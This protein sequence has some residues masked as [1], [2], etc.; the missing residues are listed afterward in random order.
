MSSITATSIFIGSNDAPAR[1]YSA[2]TT[3]LAI[4]QFYDDLLSTG[5]FNVATL[6]D[7]RHGQRLLAIVNISVFLHVA[8][9]IADYATSCATPEH[10]EVLSDND[11]SIYIIISPKAAQ[12]DFFEFISNFVSSYSDTCSDITNKTVARLKEVFTSYT[13]E[14]NIKFLINYKLSL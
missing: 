4:E 6:T 13:N 8:Q 1:T 12:E 9:A 2:A 11:E 14:P 5:H 3:D 7:P 10:F